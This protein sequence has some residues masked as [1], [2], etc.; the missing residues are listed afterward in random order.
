MS[1]KT[2]KLGKSNLVS[3]RLSYGC[4][5]IVGTWVPNEVTDERKREARAAVLA[6]YE[7]GYSSHP[8]SGGP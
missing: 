4:M 2:Q 8:F 3:T 5:R 1:M 6:A 7:A